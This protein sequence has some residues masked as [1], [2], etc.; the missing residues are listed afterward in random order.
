[1]FLCSSKDKSRIAEFW[2]C[3]CKNLISWSLIIIHSSL[4]SI[5]WSLII[6]HSSLKSISWSQLA[7]EY[8]LITD[9]HL[10]KSNFFLRRRA[11][12]VVLG[13]IVCENF[14]LMQRWSLWSSSWQSWF[15]KRL[16]LQGI[17]FRP[18]FGCYNTRIKAILRKC[19]HVMW[20]R[21]QVNPTVLECKE[22]NIFWKHFNCRFPPPLFWDCRVI[23]A[24]E[25]KYLK[26]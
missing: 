19:R 6:I 25:T 2:H 23:D 15:S 17:K 18:I 13:E 12:E 14:A 26:S 5:S 24:L 3:P 1:M 21:C 9:N 10:K 7:K 20:G 8:K 16:T 4:K 11:G 22:E